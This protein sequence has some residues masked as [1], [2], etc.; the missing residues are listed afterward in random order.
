[1]KKNALRRIG[2][3]SCVIFM[4]PL[5]AGCGS[6]FSEPF[7][8]NY[9]DSSFGII[10]TAKDTA[11]RADSFAENLCVTDG[12]VNA[13][14]IDLPS[15]VA[16]GLFDCTNKETLYA[17][18]VFAQLYPASMTKVMTAIVALDNSST[19]QVLTAGDD[20][21]QLEAGAQVAG[22]KPGD[23]LT[24]DQALH[25]L[26]IYSA[27]DAAVVIADSVA[28]NSEAFVGLMNEKAKELGATGTNFVNSNGLTDEN[29]Y[30]TPYD[31]Y[32]IFN[33][34]MNYE[35]FR[36][37]ISQ[38]SYSTVIHDSSGGDRTIN[39]SATNQYLAGNIQ[40]PTGITVVGGKTGTTSAAGHCLILYARDSSGN[41]Y[42]AVVMRTESADAMYSTMNSLLGLIRNP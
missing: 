13:D 38:Q 3:V 11:G 7:S 21:T 9:A 23:T 24:M 25:L 18:N 19:D 6:R 37:I 39:V 5:L 2:A 4:L 33:E 34:A 16:A 41:P 15:T 1:M 20:V 31:M 36:E 29:H 17:K 12:D 30:T 28:G 42:I 35:L 8:D 10:E 22:I 26:L 32:L 40:A 27:N 14:A